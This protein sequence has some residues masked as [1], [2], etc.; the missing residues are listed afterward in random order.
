MKSNCLF[1]ALSQKFKYGGIIKIRKTP[2]YYCVPRTSWSPDGITWYRFVPKHRVKN[3]T[4]LQN[5]LPF[6]VLYF[7]GYVI[8]TKGV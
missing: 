4:L 8:G 2:G 6:H 1:W 3:P 7:E 5:L